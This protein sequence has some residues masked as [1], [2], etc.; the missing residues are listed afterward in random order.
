LV[1]K[2]VALLVEVLDKPRVEWKVVVKVVKMVVQ[3][4]DWKVVV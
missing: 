2:W 1:E 3:R 4:V